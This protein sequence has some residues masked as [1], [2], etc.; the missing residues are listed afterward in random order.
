MTRRRLSRLERVKIF[1]AHQGICLHC[2][3]KIHAE[4]GEKW[5]AMHIVSLWAGGK[6]EHENMGPGHVK[7]HRE[8]TTAEAPVKAKSDR[9]RARHLG[10][11]RDRTITRWR[12]FSGEIVYAS[13]ER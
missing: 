8:Q 2:K 1:D 3:L 11:K 12:K 9:V 4:R 6:D 13:R 10:I 5:E 7:C